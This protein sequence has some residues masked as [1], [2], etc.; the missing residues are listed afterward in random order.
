MSVEA[1]IMDARTVMNSEI[2][3]DVPEWIMIART[4]TWL[5]HPL[6]PELVTPAHLRSALDFFDRNYKVNRTDL[7]IDYHHGSVLAAG[8]GQKAPAGGWINEME[9]RAGGNELWAHVHLWIA[10]A[11]NAIAAR[12]YRYLSPV[13]RWGQPDPVTGT[14]V[15]LAIPSVALTNTPFMTALEG[16]NENASTLAVGGQSQTRGF[17]PLPSLSEGGKPMGILQLLA[18]VLSKAVEEINSQLG[19]TSTEDKDVANAILAFPGKIAELQTAVADAQKKPANGVVLN[20]LGCAGGADETAVRAAILRLKA[21]GAG[22]MAVRAKLG[23]N[24]DASEAD[25]LNSIDGLRTTQRKSEAEVLVDEA[26]E[27]GKV[28]PAARDFWLHAAEETFDAAKAAINSLAVL[29][30]QGGDR[31]HADPAKKAL[32]EAQQKVCKMLNL[33]DEAFL[34]ARV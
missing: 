28:P 34:S 10:E 12:E 25:I 9:L 4:G 31:I 16:L 19:L 6:G 1:A 7:V 26:I 11:R 20:A 32:T 8:R 2:P 21:P 22:L 5:G 13:M 29:T 14:P 27:A 15:P 30:I 17:S 33:K 18:T 24:E 23:L 3:A